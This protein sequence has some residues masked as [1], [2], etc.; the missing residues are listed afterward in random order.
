MN[1]HDNEK[2]RISVSLLVVGSLNLMFG[3]TMGVIFLLKGIHEF[4]NPESYTPPSGVYLIMAI[5]AGMQIVASNGIFRGREKGVG[6][7]GLL[8]KFFRPRIHF[9]SLFLAI[10][11]ERFRLTIV[12]F[13]R[14]PLLLADLMAKLFLVPLFVSVI[15]IIQIASIYRERDVDLYLEVYGIAPPPPPSLWSSLAPPVGL[16]IWPIILI[17]FIVIRRFLMRREANK[18]RREVNVSEEPKTFN[19]SRKRRRRKRSDRD[20]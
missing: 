13:I 18:M 6:Y 1:V 3:L 5:L 14:S 20:S 8:G 11:A 17:A 9:N 12:L 15:E 16:A 19:E 2:E 10:L 4:T 7:A